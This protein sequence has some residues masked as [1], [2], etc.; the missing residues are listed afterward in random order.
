MYIYIHNRRVTYAETDR[1]G[2]LYYG[3]YA[4]YYESARVEALR[5]LGIRYRDLEDAQI[6]LP[7]RQMKCRFLRPAQYDEL[8]QVITKIPHLPYMTILFNYELRNEKGEIL[9]VGTTELVFYDNQRKRPISAP[10]TIIER[11]KPY[12]FPPEKT[13]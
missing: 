13:N 3:K 12:F 1:M 6:I 8:I 2:Y 9:N 10:D 7:V 11:L 4:E 5:A